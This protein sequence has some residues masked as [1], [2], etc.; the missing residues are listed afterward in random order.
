M[1]PSLHISI[2]IHEFT[3]CFTWNCERTVCLSITI[4]TWS[5]MDLPVHSQSSGSNYECQHLPFKK[6]IFTLAC[7]LYSI[8]FNISH[9][10][11]RLHEFVNTNTYLL[12]FSSGVT[13]S[14]LLQDFLERFL[15]NIL[16]WQFFWFLRLKPVTD[17]SRANRCRLI[18]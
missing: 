11:K 9:F 3:A 10:R 1:P 17:A 5:C 8:F 13:W 4:E 15:T 12:S 14:A 6:S 18:L 2:L 7:E 16:F